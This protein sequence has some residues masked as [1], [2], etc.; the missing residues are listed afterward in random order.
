MPVWVNWRLIIQ[1]LLVKF[2]NR[3]G[4]DIHLPI[5][6]GWIKIFERKKMNLDPVFDN[7]Q[8]TVK[9]LVPKNLKP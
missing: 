1:E 3:I 4:P 7:H 2:V 5:I 8:I 9:I 6:A